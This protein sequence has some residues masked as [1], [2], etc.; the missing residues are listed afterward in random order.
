MPLPF[1]SL[2][3]KMGNSLLAV[4]DMKYIVAGRD[5]MNRMALFSKSTGI[6]LLIVL[7]LSIMVGLSSCAS[8]DSNIQTDQ[9]LLKYLYDAYGKTDFNIRDTAVKGKYK[10][11]VFDGAEGQIGYV[12][13][14][15]VQEGTYTVVSS[16]ME[17]EYILY[18]S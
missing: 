10:L 12:F 16:K 14:E 2:S 9:D 5:V 7:L 1:N 15:E 18:F 11:A 13:L 4:R 3:S 6:K 17:T 8:K